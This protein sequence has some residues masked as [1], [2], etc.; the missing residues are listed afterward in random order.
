MT[1]SPFFTV[2]SYITASLNS[3][4]EIVKNSLVAV[5]VEIIYSW[6]IFFTIEIEVLCVLSK[7]IDFIIENMASIYIVMIED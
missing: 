2:F 3:K 4:L 1:L 7:H 6:R 5:A